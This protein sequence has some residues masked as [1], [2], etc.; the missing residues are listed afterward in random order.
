MK[1]GAVEE[2]FVFRVLPWQTFLPQWGFHFFLVQLSNHNLPQCWHRRPP[3]SYCRFGIE[4]LESHV[5]KSEVHNGHSLDHPQL[6]DIEVLHVWFDRVRGRLE[7]VV[8]VTLS[9]ELAFLWNLL[10]KQA[11]VTVPKGGI[12]KGGLDNT[13]ASV[14][15]YI[16]IS[17]CI[18]IYIYIHI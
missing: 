1:I 5:R 11:W 3:P 17:L 6:T 13:N 4:T 12:P 7:L 2:M 10:T 9:E 8:T 16:Y 18:Y 14:H 15:I